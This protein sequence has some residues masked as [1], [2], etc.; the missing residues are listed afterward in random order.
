[1]FPLYRTVK[2]E[3]LGILGLVLTHRIA[4][5]NDVKLSLIISISNYCHVL[6]FRTRTG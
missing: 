5:K 1:M 6:F 4:K 2:Q 3:F